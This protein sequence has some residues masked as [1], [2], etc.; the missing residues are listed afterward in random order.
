MPEIENN[1]EVSG[2]LA[3]VRDKIDN[4]RKRNDTTYH[5]YQGP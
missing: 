5:D 4:W 1:A 2:E 3:E